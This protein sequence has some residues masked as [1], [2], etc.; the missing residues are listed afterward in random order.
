MVAEEILRGRGELLGELS[1]LVSYIALAPFVGAV[2][3]ADIARERPRQ[4]APAA[5]SG[6]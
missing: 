1:P 6:V 2:E 5:G 4:P 3:A